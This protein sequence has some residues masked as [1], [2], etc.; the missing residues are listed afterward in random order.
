MSFI[1]FT[2]KSQSHP[3]IRVN[4]YCGVVR[5]VMI[6]HG[7]AMSLMG[8]ARTKGHVQSALTLDPGSLE[9]KL[10]DTCHFCESLAKM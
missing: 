10:S 9:G 6:V 8:T 1:H 7:H 2:E 3:V 4:W 5:P